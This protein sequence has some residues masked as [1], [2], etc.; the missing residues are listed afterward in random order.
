MKDSISDKRNIVLTGMPGCGK[1]VTGVVL[2]KSLNKSFVDTDLLIQER[3]GRSLQDII[4]EDGTE[5]FKEIER[6]V[7]VSL[8]TENTVIATGGSAVYYPDAMEHLREGGDIIYIEAPLE[9]I[10][11]RLKN[12]KTRGV[13]MEKGQSIAELYALREPLYRKYADITVMT[14]RGS[15]ERTVEKMIDALRAIQRRR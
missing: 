12:I 1:S 8:D 13:A 14:D 2:A 10:E 11:K 4:N 6:E 7:L 9:V 3:E 5:R 15:V